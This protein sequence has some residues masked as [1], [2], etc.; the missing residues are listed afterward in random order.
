MGLLTHLYYKS[1]NNHVF[2][3]AFGIELARVVAVIAAIIVLATHV[4][5]AWVAVVVAV[6]LMLL[7]RKVTTIEWHRSAAALAPV[8]VLGILPIN[9]VTN[10]AA[11]KSTELAF[12]LA[13]LNSAVRIATLVYIVCANIVRKPFAEAWGCY[14]TPHMSLWNEGP[15][16]LYTHDYFHSW[17]C[18]D[19]AHTDLC[20]RQTLP[21]SYNTPGKS[22]MH[23][24][25][26]V[27]V[28]YGIHVANMLLLVVDE[29]HGYFRAQL[30]HDFNT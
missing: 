9:F 29:W 7:D 26:V 13:Y 10:I 25:M 24:M 23:A 20:T 17:V 5:R 16:P 18:R 4:S 21:D 28:L 6:A 14:G 30:L 19:N 1:S 8:F 27:T 3:P 22:E 12:V 15:C 2:Y 11:D